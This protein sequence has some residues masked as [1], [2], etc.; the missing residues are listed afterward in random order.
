MKIKIK[1]GALCYIGLNE[2]IN[3]FQII[4][5]KLFEFDI[6]IILSV[7]CLHCAYYHLYKNVNCINI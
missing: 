7:S 4:N 6:Q 1:S 2:I 5:K 3:A